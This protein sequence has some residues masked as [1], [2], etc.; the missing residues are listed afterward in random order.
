MRPTIQQRGVPRCSLLLHRFLVRITLAIAIV[1]FLNSPAPARQGASQEQS[2]EALVTHNVRLHAAASANSK[3]LMVLQRGERLAVVDSNPTDGFYHVQAEGGDEG[4]VSER[5]VKIQATPA[6]A[7]AL[8][9][10]ASPPSSE[11]QETW[12]K[13]A[14]KKTTFA[15][16]EG[17]CPWNGNDSDPDTF[18]RKNRSDEPD[19]AKVH[20]VAWSAIHDL[21]FPKDKPLRVNWSKENLTEI[22]KYEG[23]AVRTVGFIVAIKPQNGHGEGT[24]CGFSLAADTDTHIALVGEEGD[25][26]KN[27]VV[28]EFTPRFLKAHP[29]WN[30]KVLSKF[31]DNGIPVRITGWL[32]LD[33]DHRNHLNRFRFTLW[34]IHPITRIEAL[35]NGQWLDVDNF[36]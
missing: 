22:A 31:E 27:S 2:K 15:G 32:M 30:K 34:E 10:P 4:W 26:E 25:A 21:P 12:D 24:N 7:L 36:K 29:N 3:S 6:A 23:V 11:I 13:P 28:I 9:S 1:A 5:Y 16:P 35:Q 18:V 14:P 33:P 8:M 17:T 19:D 20:D